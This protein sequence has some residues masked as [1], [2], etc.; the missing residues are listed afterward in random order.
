MLI[1]IARNSVTAFGLLAI[2]VVSPMLLHADEK[3]DLVKAHYQNSLQGLIDNKEIPDNVKGQLFLKNVND[4]LICKTYRAYVQKRF[5]D[6]K[7]IQ[8]FRDDEQL[9]SRHL[10]EFMN[11]SVQVKLASEEE[12]KKLEA[13]LPQG[14]AKIS[15]EI[16]G[17]YERSN[18]SGSDQM[19]DELYGLVKKC[20]DLVWNMKMVEIKF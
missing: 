10:N 9:I 12:R 3:P 1:N 19:S 14:E 16:D 6:M 4:M 8:K 7:D 2:F 17:V 20:D 5:P 13:S 18:N 11:A 15:G